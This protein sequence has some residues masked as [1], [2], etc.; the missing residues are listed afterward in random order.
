MENEETQVTSMP[1][2][3]SQTILVFDDCLA[4]DPFACANIGEAVSAYAAMLSGINR[5][6]LYFAYS[7]GKLLDKEKLASRFKVTSIDA[8]SKLFGVSVMTL[9]RYRQVH[10]LLTPAQVKQLASRMISINAVLKIADYARGDKAKADKMLD[11][12]MSGELKTAKDIDEA[13]VNELD[14]RLRPYNLL[15]GGTPSDATDSEE[16]D[17]QRLLAVE[18]DQLAEQELSVDPEFE[19]FVSEAPKKPKDSSKKVVKDDDEEDED[20][21][22]NKRDITKLLSISLSEIS[23]I[24][25][26]L[27][28]VHEIRKQLDTLHDRAAVIMGDSEQFEKYN[29]ALEELYDDLCTAVEVLVPEA[30]RGIAHGLLNRK[31]LLLD[32][33]DPDEVF[34][35]ED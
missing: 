28:S 6:S 10:D 19:D 32:S 23:A 18:A 1:I 29:D 22:Q 7:M 12:V 9:W 26:S 34:R 33:T 31:C 13:I 15:P 16:F 35:K 14:Q 25:R 30:K 4:F 27:R 2:V 3:D 11:A 8:V 21:T 20:D 24:R 5:C 17:N